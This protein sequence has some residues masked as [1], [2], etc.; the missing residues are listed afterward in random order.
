MSTVRIDE[1]SYY[2]RDVES[3]KGVIVIHEIFGFDPYIKSIADSL[4]QSGFKSVA[5]DLYKRKIA[6]S[7][8]EGMQLRSQI[9][10]QM[11]KACIGGAEKILRERGASKVGV[12]GFC[13]GG[14]FS[15]QS[16]CDLGLDF[17]VDFYGLIQ[18]ENDVS[19]LKGPLLLILASKDERVTGW[20]LQ[21]LLPAAVKFE[22]RV[23]AHLYPNT[24][25]A[26]HRPNWQGH[27]KEAAED[28]WLRTID[29]ISRV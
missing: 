18:D 29:F 1:W 9:S 4:A 27:N 5:V 26:F 22:K 2:V 13:M 3:S 7:L 19:K 12:L 24:V 10:G 15:L 6:A 16:A 17:C 8:E 20:A 25:H 14:G 28:S 11:L 23:E 21:R